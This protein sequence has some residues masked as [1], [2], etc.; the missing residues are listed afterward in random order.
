MA[1]VSQSPITLHLDSSAWTLSRA[2]SK[3]EAVSDPHG[4]PSAAT[5]YLE[6]TTTPGGVE[7]IS[8]LFPPIPDVVSIIQV[9]IHIRSRE[10]SGVANHAPLLTIAGVDYN[11]TGISLP[12]GV[13]T[14][15][16]D[17]W[18]VDPV[19]GL[20]FSKATVDAMGAGVVQAAATA[21]ARLTQIVREVEFVPFAAKVGPAID[22]G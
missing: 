8:F 1:K 6:C 3:P 11:G 12:V 5:D 22:L 19:T 14:D 10:E 20:A 2:A 7:R 15:H 9:T 17:T 21:V 13:W 18:T 4:R 16:Q